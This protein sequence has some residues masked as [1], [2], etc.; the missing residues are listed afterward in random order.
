MDSLS[1]PHAET[2]EPT[3]AESDATEFVPDNTDWSDAIN[4][5]VPR[6]Q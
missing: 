3:L 6:N 1:L 4:T 5:S 2:T